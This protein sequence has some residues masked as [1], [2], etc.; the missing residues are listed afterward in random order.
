MSFCREVSFDRFIHH[1][2]EGDDVAQW[3]DRTL[4]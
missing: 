3:D 4:E 1:R 2:N